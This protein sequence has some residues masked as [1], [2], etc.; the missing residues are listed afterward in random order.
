MAL[1]LYFCF[2]LKKQTPNKTN[3]PPQKKNPQRLVL[4]KAC[5]GVPIMAQW[6]ANPTKNPEVVGSVPAL[7]QWVGDLALP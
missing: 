4:K 1:S 5:P 2:L 6:L 7:A 3:T